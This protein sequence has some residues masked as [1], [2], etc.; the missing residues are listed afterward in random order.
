MKP[1]TMLTELEAAA[2][3]LTVKVSY[4]TLLS[5]VGMGGLCRVKGQLRVIIDKRANP[6][7][8]VATLA[9]A[10]SK[11][12][13]DALTLSRPVREVIEYYSLRRAS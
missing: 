3:A 4:E 2:T 11:L 13:T 7:E 1:D 9:Q 8:R 12:D 5:S 10:L 6:R